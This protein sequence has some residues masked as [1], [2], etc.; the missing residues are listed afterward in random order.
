MKN[1][2]YKLKL[3]FQ[4]NFEQQF[5]FF[6]RTNNFYFEQIL[7]SH[8]ID[9]YYTPINKQ[10]SRQY[11]FKSDI[12]L[13]Y[14]QIH[15][16][17]IIIIQ[18]SLTYFTYIQQNFQT[19]ES[20]VI[21]LFRIGLQI[22]IKS[23]SNHEKKIAQLLILFIRILNYW[24]SLPRIMMENYQSINL[25]IFLFCFCIDIISQLRSF[26]DSITQAQLIE[27][28][29]N[30][31]YQIQQKQFENKY[32]V[33]NIVQKDILINIK[34][35]YKFYLFK[36][37]IAQFFLGVFG[38]QILSCL[39]Q[40]CLSTK[41]QILLSYESLKLI[42]GSKSTGQSNGTTSSLTFLPV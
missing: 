18:I 15:P 42:S 38:S 25:L 23:H 27:I 22:L 12:C 30:I 17:V 19:T 20:L 1:F 29:K 41:I 24:R 5:G 35:E 14:T 31:Q 11:H 34:K 10:E 4:S 40:V 9:L 36:V 13:I 21:L 39:Y 6:S 16:Q 26:R 2:I 8:I 7:Q 3:N 37:N 28:K 33:N 32:Q